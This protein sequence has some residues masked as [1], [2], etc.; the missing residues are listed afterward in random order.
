MGDSRDDSC[1]S[2]PFTIVYLTI[3][4]LCLV[5]IVLLLLD[6]YYKLN[7]TQ[8]QSKAVVNETLQFITV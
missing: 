2:A 1:F 8:P 4:L 5:I 7:F 3:A 6:W